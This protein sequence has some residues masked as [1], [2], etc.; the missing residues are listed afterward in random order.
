MRSL[1]HAVQK[2]VAQKI[3]ALASDPYPRGSKKLEAEGN[4]HRIRV[5]DYRIIYQVQQAILVVF[6]VRVKHRGSVYRP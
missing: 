6:V 2:R 3:D 4:L 5:G 1:P